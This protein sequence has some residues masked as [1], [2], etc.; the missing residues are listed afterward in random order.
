[1]PLL[2]ERRALLHSK[3]MLL[4]NHQA[5]QIAEGDIGLDE[6]VCADDD[7]HLARSQ[8]RI[9]RFLVRGAAGQEFNAGERGA[10]SA[11]NNWVSV[12]KCCSARIS[13]GA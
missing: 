6:R 4:V 1:V 2:S 13:V 5:G 11:P 10:P 7:V 3:A 12:L 8:L 9:D